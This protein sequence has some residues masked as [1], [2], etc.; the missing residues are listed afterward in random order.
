MAMIKQKVN[1]NC[2]SVMKLELSNID[3]IPGNTG[4]GCFS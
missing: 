1:V 2:G 3:T 4:L